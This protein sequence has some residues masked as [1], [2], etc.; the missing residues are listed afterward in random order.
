M[1]IHF[2]HCHSCLLRGQF[3]S[4]SNQE[5]RLDF[6][7]FFSEWAVVGRGR[8]G[9]EEGGGGSLD[10][11]TRGVSVDTSVFT[12]QKRRKWRMEAADI[13][14][15]K[16]ENDLCST[17]QILALFRGQ[18]WGDCWETG[19]SAYGP[20]RAL[21]C[22][23]ELKLELKL[24]LNSRQGTCCNCWNVSSNVGLGLNFGLSIMWH[25]GREGRGGGAIATGF[26]P[27][28][29]VMSHATPGNGFNQYKRK[30]DGILTLSNLLAVL[31]YRTVCL[32]CVKHDSCTAPLQL[33]RV[34]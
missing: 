5:I 33:E 31:S 6:F 15:S 12:A 32:N 19:R 13:P 29:P 17:R 34:S 9:E 27:D 16:V 24:K 23:L 14:P 3:K 22:H 20:F 4:I 21:L 1:I 25:W 8:A 28:I 26:L 2:T 18:P 30:I 7:F 10:G 11:T